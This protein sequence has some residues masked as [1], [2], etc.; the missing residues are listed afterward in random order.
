M[1]ASELKAILAQAGDLPNFTLL[2]RNAKFVREGQG[3]EEAA[4]RTMAERCTA[5]AKEYHDRHNG[6][7]GIRQD[8]AYA[9]EY[10]QRA[11]H[12]LTLADRVR[13]GGVTHNDDLLT[14]QE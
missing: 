14:D 7:G 12:Y 5:I 3:D 11:N 10:Y 2:C 8:Y 9:Q 4:L 6:P 13:D 1:R